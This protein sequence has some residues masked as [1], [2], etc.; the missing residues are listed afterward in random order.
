MF[1]AIPIQFLTGKHQT[2]DIAYSD[3]A[4]QLPQFQ[5]VI[6]PCSISLN[7]CLNMEFLIELFHKNTFFKSPACWILNGIHIP[8][9]SDNP[10]FYHTR[11]TYKGID[12]ITYH[13]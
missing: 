1:H 4:T 9:L 13:H 10:I 8:T 12:T 7:V 11:V 2:V 6:I 5:L 3:S